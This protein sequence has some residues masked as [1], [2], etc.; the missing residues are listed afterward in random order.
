MQ[1]Q[2][3]YG[4]IFLS[5]PEDMFID[6]R[7]RGINL[8]FHLLMHLLLDACLC[9]HWGLNLQPWCIGTVLSPTE[10]PGQGNTFFYYS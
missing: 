7:E 6:F 4:I 2:I 10:L 3:I 9:P 1:Y 8:S 5:L